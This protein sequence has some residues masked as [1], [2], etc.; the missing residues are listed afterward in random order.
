MV[1]MPGFL[2]AL[3]IFTVPNKI[4]IMFTH[5]ALVMVRANISRFLH[6]RSIG[7]MIHFADYRGVYQTA[8]VLHFQI[9]G[10]SDLGANNR[11]HA[12]ECSDVGLLAQSKTG[13]F[14]VSN[15][16]CGKTTVHHIH[17]NRI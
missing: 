10:S 17:L 9:L 8:R 7:L 6:I 14:M 11:V 3:S 1:G 4:A 16:Y 12:A 13:H 5:S 2:G 15:D